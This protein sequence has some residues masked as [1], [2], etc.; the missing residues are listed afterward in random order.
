MVKNK[1]IT[2]EQMLTLS[3]ITKTKFNN[4]DDKFIELIKKYSN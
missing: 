3:G 1:P 2:E 4:F